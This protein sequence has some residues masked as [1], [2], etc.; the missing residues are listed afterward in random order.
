MKINDIVA[1]EPSTELAWMRMPEPDR[2]KVAEMLKNTSLTQAHTTGES[3]RRALDTGHFRIIYE[4]TQDG[5]N[6]IVVSVATAREARI[7]RR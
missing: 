6:V 7:L 3:K 1:V 4:V 5:A 2:Q